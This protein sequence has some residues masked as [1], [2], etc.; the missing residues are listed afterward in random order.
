[1]QRLIV[2]G[3]SAGGV[4]ALRTLASGLP[5]DLPCPLLVVLHIG[6]HPSVLPQLLSRTGPLPARSAVADERI[7]PGHIY[8][9][10]PD[11]HMLVSGETILLTRGPKAHHS[12][13]AVDPLFLSAALA[14]G[15]GAVGV[16]LTGMLDDGTSGLQAI[17]RCGGVAV[18]QD[19]A[20]AY[21]PSMPR[22]ALDNVDVDHCVGLARLPALLAEL[23][24]APLPAAAPACPHDLRHE[25]ALTLNQGDA[26]MKLRALGSPSPFVCPE[27]HGGLWALRA[28]RPQRF[29]CHTGHFYTLRTLQH[30]LSLATDEAMWNALRALQEKQIVLEQM[31]ASA[32]AGD[33]ALA[34][35]TLRYREAAAEVGTQVEALHSLIERSPEAIE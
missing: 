20:Q 19:P 31:A 8:V 5:A 33:P 29:R 32:D 34:A 11:H 25:M 18:V 23:A 9:A 14:R 26:M 13:P 24:A 4:H 1:M 16:V 6:P 35:D 3:A 22:S 2:V 10:P 15:P 28:E 27:C 30:A 21:A 12:R 7:E 17:K